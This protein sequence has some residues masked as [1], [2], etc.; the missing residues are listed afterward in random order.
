MSGRYAPPPPPPVFATAQSVGASAGGAGTPLPS[1]RFVIPV[2]SRLGSAG[3]A[4]QRLPSAPTT[5]RRAAAVGDSPRGGR[6]R[7]GPS[8]S[9]AATPRPQSS[10]EEG[11]F[12]SARRRPAPEGVAPERVQH[13]HRRPDNGHRIG[14]GSVRECSPAGAHGGGF[15]PNSSAFP[16]GQSLRPNGDGFAQQQQQQQ[17]SA[18]PFPTG[19]RPQSAQRRASSAS[20]AARRPSSAARNGRAAGPDGI[21][22][23]APMFPSSD[24]PSQ[25]AAIGGASS[26]PSFAA[27]TAAQQQYTGRAPNALLGAGAAAQL[28]TLLYNSLSALLMAADTCE[29]LIEAIPAA[30]LHTVV[31]NN[32]GGGV[33]GQQQQQR[34][35]RPSAVGILADIKFV[36]EAGKGELSN[37]LL[38]TVRDLSGGG[39]VASSSAP[40]AGGGAAGHQQQL[41]MEPSVAPSASSSGGKP[42]SARGPR[43]DIAAAASYAASNCYGGPSAALHQ[44][45]QQQQQGGAASSS[46]SASAV[47]SDG[48]QPQHSPPLDGI[49]GG[50]LHCEALLLAMAALR[51]S[52]G[53]L[54]AEL[55]AD[56]DAATAVAA[57]VAGGKDHTPLRQQQQQRGSFP[58]SVGRPSTATRRGSLPSR[59]QSAASP[60][61]P[62]PAAAL[63]L[64]VAACDASLKDLTARAEAAVADTADV[65]MLCVARW[66]AALVP[67]V[68]GDGSPPFPQQ[69]RPSGGGTADPSGPMP[70]AADG[71]ATCNNACI[72]IDVDVLQEV[73]AVFEARRAALLMG[74]SSVMYTTPSSAPAHRQQPSPQSPTI[75]AGGGGNGSGSNGNRFT[76]FEEAPSPFVTS[77]R[78][79]MSASGGDSPAP[80]SLGAGPIHR[81]SSSPIVTS[82]ALAEAFPFYGDC[83]N[84]TA[85][86][87]S[88][89]KFGDDGDGEVRRRT[90]HVYLA[91]RAA[92]LRRTRYAAVVSWEETRRLFMQ[93]RVGAVGSDPYTHVPSPSAAAAADAS[94]GRPKTAA[95]TSGVGFTPTPAGAAFQHRSGSAS[96]RPA[97]AAG[98]FFASRSGGP[99]NVR[100][101]SASIFAAF[102]AGAAHIS[103]LNTHF[104]G[105]RSIGP[106]TAAPPAGPSPAALLGAAIR[107]DEAL[108]KRYDSPPS[109]SPTAAVVVASVPPWPDKVLAAAATMLRLRYDVSSGTLLKDP[110]NNN[111]ASSSSAAV[112]LTSEAH[113][114]LSSYLKVL[115]RR[116]HP[117]RFIGRC[118]A[119]A[120][121]SPLSATASPSSAAAGGDSLVVAKATK[122]SQSINA[123]RD[124]LGAAV[125][126]GAPSS[127]P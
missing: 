50:M 67:A 34:R 36:R 55:K 5:P 84:G 70:G 97:S 125:H 64:A 105:A 20:A 24:G 59:P 43:G 102:R 4:P 52:A 74:A 85:S 61:P 14:E 114:T 93:R 30:R 54:A 81:R 76:A 89:F 27:S 106:T 35:L 42:L 121:S 63:L 83:P 60:P 92:S 37:A 87:F 7:A 99:N 19:A 96:Q 119:A 108:W 68:D 107:T 66:T 120:S 62:S 109:A 94:G 98:A 77:V 71:A 51:S 16:A 123:L 127:H 116:W 103:N 6:T 13:L 69:R 2:H 39:L 124:A 104:G 90:A 101:S 33:G 38:R 112:V 122:I 3:S 111:S 9:P 86:H 15:S 57:A 115:Q 88:P 95:P 31:A 58:P 45:Q 91:E 29:G 40:S 25:S 28:R 100:P 8:P 26:V 1:P 113:D 80:S 10:G 82:A 48:A 118:A 110:T 47:A 11:V 21:L 49:I 126:S 17:Q 12:N 18:S 41:R 44:Q 79:R 72:V 75:P 53:R 65:L 46:P 23:F 117:D 32:T 22:S 73:A 78:R 56:A